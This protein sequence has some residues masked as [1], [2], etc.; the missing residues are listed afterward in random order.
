M[1]SGVGRNRVGSVNG[2]GANLDVKTIGF[3]PRVVVINN[4]AGLCMGKWVEGMADATAIKTVTDGTISLA[5]TLGITP[6]SNGFRIGADT[7][8]NVDGELI[9]WEAYE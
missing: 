2:T 5:A 6:L 1:S 3:K 9:R 8:L 4:I 7:D